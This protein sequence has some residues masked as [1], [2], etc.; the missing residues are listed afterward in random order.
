M[1]IVCPYCHQIIDISDEEKIY[2]EKDK[3]FKINNENPKCP[4]C[5][6]SFVL[7]EEDNIIEIESE[8]KKIGLPSSCFGINSAY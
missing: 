2:S 8:R 6:L 7:I 3:N 4:N 5:G 1:I